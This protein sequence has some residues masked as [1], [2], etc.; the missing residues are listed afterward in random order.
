M[1]WRRQLPRTYDAFFGGFPDLLPTQKAAIPLLLRGNNLL[2]I[3][4][5]GSGKTEAVVAPLAEE[6]SISRGKLML[7]TSHQP[8][9]WPTTWKCD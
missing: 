4:P 9:R 6:H 3:A 7:F 2:L 8:E 5:T 1:N